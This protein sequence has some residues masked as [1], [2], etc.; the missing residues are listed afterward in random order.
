VA[1]CPDQLGPSLLRVLPDDH[2]RIVSYPRFNDPTIIDWVD[3]GAAIKA[4]S[5]VRFLDHVAA[6]VGQHNVWLVWSP[7]YGSFK[8]MCQN[9]AWKFL[10]AQGW[11][12]RD[13]VKAKPKVFYQSM[14]LTQFVP[15][16]AP[17]SSGH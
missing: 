11:N 16:G 6:E 14:N 12:G 15:P 1:I 17:A 4:T 3:Y 10:H 13:W 2:Y 8:M 9:L 5:P 7:G